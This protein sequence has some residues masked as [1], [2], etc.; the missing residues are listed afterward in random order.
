MI[1]KNCGGAVPE[2]GAFTPGDEALL[3]GLALNQALVHQQKLRNT[4]DASSMTEI[5]SELAVL[6]NTIRKNADQWKLRRLKT[7][8]RSYRELSLASLR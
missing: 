3:T 1:G 4:P 5:Q 6:R 7:T 2:P 8:L